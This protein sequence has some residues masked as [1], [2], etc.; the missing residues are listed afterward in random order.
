MQLTSCYWRKFYSVVTGVLVFFEVINYFDSVYTDHSSPKFAEI[1]RWRIRRL[2]Q[3]LSVCDI[4]FH[5]SSRAT[6]KYF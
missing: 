5:A 6:D 3:P 1:A 2:D 4:H